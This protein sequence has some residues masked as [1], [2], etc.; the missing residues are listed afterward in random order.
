VTISQAWKWGGTFIIPAPGRLRPE[1]LQ[2]EASVSR[3]MVYVIRIYDFEGEGW[4]VLIKGTT[5]NKE[6]GVKAQAPTS[7]A[8]P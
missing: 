7:K 8:A 6:P 1:D 3:K 2:F 5:H 4:L